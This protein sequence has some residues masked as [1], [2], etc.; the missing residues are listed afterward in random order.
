MKT[1]V[2]IIGGGPA[3]MFLS[4]LL[5]QVGIDAVVLERRS[6]DYVEGRIRAGLLERGTV[7]TMR[8]LG[9]DARVN[10]EGLV[11]G[12]I[13]LVCDG[14]MFHIDLAGLTGS[15]VT[16]YGQSEVMKDLFDA[17][18]PEPSVN[19]CPTRPRTDAEAIGRN[20]FV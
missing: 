20:F 8:R 13:N 17:S 1:Q 15:M 16:V 11:H 4:H 2:A 5:R 3:G 19:L 10:R 14:N 6:R 9:V 18:H 7:E 12:G